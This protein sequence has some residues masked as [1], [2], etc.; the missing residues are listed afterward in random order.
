MN[1]AKRLAGTTLA[2]MLAASPV[3]G[4]TAAWGQMMRPDT[5]SAVGASENVDA[6]DQ[7][8]AYDI[9]QAWS[10]DEDASGAVAFQENGEIALSDGNR[11]QARHY[12]EAAETELAR[13]KPHPVSVMS[14]SAK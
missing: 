2:L 5:G 6:M 8:V 1:R 11:E 7:K 13:L 9:N 14:S 4:V 12:F 10:R 3:I